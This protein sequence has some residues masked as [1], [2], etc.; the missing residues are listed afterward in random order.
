MKTKHSYFSLVLM[1]FLLIPVF[2][3]ATTRYVSLAGSNT[4]PY[5]SLADAATNIQTAIAVCNDGDV[6]L[7]NDGS[8][9]LSSNVS[10]TIGITVQS[11][12]G[13]EFTIVDGNH[14]TRCFYIDNPNALL[15]GFT[16]QNGYNPFDFGGGIDINNA[17]TVENCIIQNCQARDGGGVALDYGGLVQNCIISNNIASN[18][19]PEGYGGGVRLLNGGEIRNC[20]ITYNSSVYLGGGVNIWESGKVKNCVISKNTCPNGAG[21]RTRNNGLVFNT[22]SYYNNGTNYEVS[23]SGYYYYNCCTTPAL[24]G[25]YSSNCISSEPMFVSIISGSEDY[26]LLSGSPC[27]D[28]GMNI[29]WMNTVPDL[30]GNPRIVNGTV[31]MGAYEF[32]APVSPDSDGDGILDVDDDYPTDP[33]RAFNNYFPASGFGTLGFED[34][35][36][37][38]GDYDFNDLV[39]D[40]QFK[41]VTNA[42]NIIVEMFGTFTIKAF[43]ATF[44]NGFGFQFPDDHVLSSDLEATG[45]N[46]QSGTY[47]TLNPNGLESGQSRPTIIVY[48]DAFGLM[49]HPG[50]GIGVNTCLYAPNVTP[51]TLEIHLDFTGGS[52]T[53]EDV[54]I[55]QFN[56][57][58]IVNKN[59]SREVHLPDYPPTSLADQGIFGQ[60]DDN[61]NPAT[62]RYYRTQNN[63]PWAINIYESFEYPVEK[64]EISHAYLHFI[65]WGES[66]GTLYPNWYQNIVGYR[67]DGNIY[68]H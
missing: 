10:I 9:L 60:D 40:Y 62:G 34:L 18:N 56:P 22:I 20:E 3:I 58:I 14:L 8:Y 65:E 48:D 50:S 68:H 42:S 37:A 46:L 25:S 39:C 33:T 55:N 2:G 44:H 24:S 47:I 67:N 41:T 17:G 49:P 19:G 30:D 54:N 1:I 57:F 27:I 36:P 29:E 31:D 35:W 63:L 28:T 6:V 59:R 13:A 16:I 53:I 23:G 21:I 45:S 51:V 52:Y 43:G 64:S 11:M 66:G 5:T 38:K 26:R 15:K 4:S 7:V 32:L 12:N 61:S